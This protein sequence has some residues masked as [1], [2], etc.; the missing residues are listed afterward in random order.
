MLILP[1]KILYKEDGIEIGGNLKLSKNTI[2]ISL[3]DVNKGLKIK[4]KCNINN[5]I[6]SQSIDVSLLKE[7]CSNLKSLEKESERKIIG[8][9]C[10]LSYQQINQLKSEYPFFCIKKRIDNINSFLESHKISCENDDQIIYNIFII[11]SITYITYLQLLNTSEFTNNLTIKSNYNLKNHYTKNSMNFMK[12]A[13]RINYM[14]C[15]SVINNM[16]YHIIYF[17]NTWKHSFIKGDNLN[18]K[19]TQIM[20]EMLIFTYNGQEKLLEEQKHNH[21]THSNEIK[22]SMLELNKYKNDLIFEIN[23]LKSEL[24]DIKNESNMIK[25]YHKNIYQDWENTKNEFVDIIN[26]TK[27][28]I[29]NFSNK[30]KEDLLNYKIEKNESIE[31]ES[32]SS[33]CNTFIDSDLSG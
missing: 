2:M 9:I 27:L 17:I 3:K 11:Q 15:N 24:S 26:E 6:F 18:K 32:D 25:K 19:L 21:N 12:Y 4:V 7:L 33:Y 14:T 5:I 22:T 16:L 20:E 10:N 1:N 31:S 8:C 29:L 30:I 28:D 13:I 23:K